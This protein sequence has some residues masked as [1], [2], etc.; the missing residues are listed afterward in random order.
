MVA[1]VPGAAGV[2]AVLQALLAGGV[3]R[4]EFPVE[5]GLRGH[6]DF[7]A[8]DGF[9]R[10]VTLGVLGLLAGVEELHHPEHVSVVG[11]G[12]G[13]HA[14]GPALL[15]EFGDAGEPVEKGVLGVQMEMGE[16]HGLIL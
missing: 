1:G 8:Q 5:P 10:P 16:A 14:R 12:H 13:G 2:H 7:A 9:H 6:V 3:L 4:L 11:D 15:H